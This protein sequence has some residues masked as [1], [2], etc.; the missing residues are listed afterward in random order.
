MLLT[1]VPSPCLPSLP[2]PRRYI[3]VSSP[4]ILAQTLPLPQSG[5]WLDLSHMP[6]TALNHKICPQ[7][8]STK[9]FLTRP[10]LRISSAGRGVIFS[11]FAEIGSCHSRL[12]E[13]GCGCHEQS[14]S[15]AEKASAVYFV[16][17]II[18]LGY[19]KFA[20]IGCVTSVTSGRAC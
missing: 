4:S 7:S 3:N 14:V 2:R 6:P 20:D 8:L 13:S 10:N 9:D 16:N 17:L 18:K 1:R 5:L 19:C 15:G 12:V 11:H